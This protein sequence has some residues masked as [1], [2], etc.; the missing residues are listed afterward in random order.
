MWWLGLA[1]FV[2]CIIE[3][4]KI[5]DEQ[6][7]QWFTLLSISEYLMSPLSRPRIILNP[8][9]LVFELISAYGDVG[10]SLGVPYV[11]LYYL[12]VVNEHWF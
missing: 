12:L 1:F 2:V 7:L 8:R 3:R 10:L 11:S 4:S 5:Q 6:N 9:F